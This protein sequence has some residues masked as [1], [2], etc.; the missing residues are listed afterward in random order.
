MTLYQF[1]SD[2]GTPLDAH[3]EIE[4][5]ELILHSRSGTIGTA[6]ARNTKYGPALRILLARIEQSNL[7]LVGVWVDSSR[8]QSLPM[9]ER[10][11][12]S[13]EDTKITPTEL[14]TKLSNKMGT[15]G[16]GPN[17]QSS[18]G[19]PNKKLRFSFAGNFTDE[20]IA[21]IAC[22]GKTKK[23]ASF[24][25][26]GVMLNSD[27]REWAEGNPKLVTHLQ[28]ERSS[29]LASKKKAAFIDKHGQLHCEHCGLVPV[30]VYGADV[31][32]ACIEVHHKLPLVDMLPGHNTQLEDLMCLCANCHRVIHRELRNANR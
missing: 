4:N 19:N 16:R 22:W 25:D 32:D 9:E 14:F 18:R 12:F 31:G 11:I 30:K 1:H 17:I 15:V 10:Q 3:F 7:K 28:R 6:N 5:G 13:S 24:W 2:S 29:G 27:D 20:Q 23:D 21:R 26:N 8:V